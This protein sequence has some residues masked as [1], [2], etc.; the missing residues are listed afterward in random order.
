M[1]NRD[2]NQQGAPKRK[3]RRYS[4]EEKAAALVLLRSN[5]NLDKPLA[6]TANAL[7]VPESNLVMWRKG[8]GVSE[9]ALQ[10]VQQESKTLA[11]I[12]RDV[13]TLGAMEMRERLSDADARASMQSADLVRITGMSAEKAQLLSGAPTAITRHEDAAALA[14]LRAKAEALIAEILP[15]Y[16]GD[17]GA[18]LA[19]VR[20]QAPTLS[21]YIQ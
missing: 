5:S 3:R 20:E 6:A 8:R 11:D 18:A 14:D 1:Q 2:D 19:A 12:F 4:D 7:Q 17:R 16:G 9:Y 10:L 13:A 15:H 21:K